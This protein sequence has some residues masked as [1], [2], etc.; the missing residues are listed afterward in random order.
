VPELL[1][2][3][4]HSKKQRESNVQRYRKLNPDKRNLHPSSP[5]S[6]GLLAIYNLVYPSLQQ[7]LL[8]DNSSATYVTKS[9]SAHQPAGSVKQ[10]VSILI[11]RP[12]ADNRPAGCAP[13]LV[14]RKE[15]CCPYQSFQSSQATGSEHISL[16]CGIDFT[17]KLDFNELE[18]LSR[19]NREGILPGTT[20]T[21][22][23]RSTVLCS[24]RRWERVLLGSA[25]TFPDWRAIQCSLPR[26]AS[27]FL[28]RRT[29]LGSCWHGRG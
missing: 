10:T 13:S 22:L 3:T 20:R 29:I 16:Q 4:R 2:P 14:E 25:W 6:A 9:S 24:R 18:L 1:K 15:R 28:C 11:L 5:L 7:L 23:R 17:H 8:F 19:R 12:D 26:S 21:S 27:S